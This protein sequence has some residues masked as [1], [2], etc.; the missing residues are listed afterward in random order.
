MTQIQPW[1]T[2]KVTVWT[3]DFASLCRINIPD[4]W[5]LRIQTPGEGRGANARSH[6]RKIFGIDH[7]GEDAARR[8]SF[9]YLVG[10]E[11]YL[12]EDAAI[13]AAQAVMSNPTP[14]G[15]TASFTPVWMSPQLRDRVGYLAAEEESKQA[16]MRE[17]PGTLPK[18]ITACTAWF[19]LNHLSCTGVT[20]EPVTSLYAPFIETANA[21]IHLRRQSFARF[22]SLQNTG[23]LSWLYVQ[24]NRAVKM[25]EASFYEIKFQAIPMRNPTFPSRQLVDRRWTSMETTMLDPETLR[26]KSPIRKHLLR[27][28]RRS[29]RT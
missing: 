8:T 1:Q 11:G 24:R 6:M 7:L 14:T 18:F 12:Q 3:S 22:Q 16:Y 10:N 17:L 4:T 28:A 29:H 13:I 26:C 20:M 21:S 19:A 2:E 15:A 23:A 25:G 5:K 27:F 9:I